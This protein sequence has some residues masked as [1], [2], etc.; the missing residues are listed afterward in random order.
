MNLFLKP[1]TL[2]SDMDYDEDWPIKSVTFTSC[3][4]L[5]LMEFL[6]IT[7]WNSNNEIYYYYNV[8]TMVSVIPI[9]KMCMFSE[10]L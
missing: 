5:V 7:A 9:F 4:A 6:Y 2:N 8:R 3:R 1:E 10:F